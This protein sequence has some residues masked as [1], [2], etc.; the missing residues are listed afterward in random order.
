MTRELQ[1]FEPAGTIRIQP[2]KSIL[3]RAL[4]CAALADGT[5]TIRNFALSKDIEATMRVLEGL[6]HARFEY[7]N[8]LCTVR[9]GLRETPVDLLDCGES[10]T[11]LR[12][13]FPLALDGR[14]HVFTG[15][16][17]LME[18]P[19]GPYEDV[20][21]AQHI[22]LE[23]AGNGIQVCGQLHSAAVY[24]PGNVSSQFI[25]GLLLGFSQVSG[26][27]QII[28]TTPLESAPYVDLTRDMM[29]AFGAA[30]QA[31][32][33]TFLVRGPQL[34]TP[35]SLAAE[36]DYSHA[37]FFAAAAALAGEVTLEGLRR[38]SNQGDRAILEIVQDAGADVE[39]SGQGVTVSKGTL[40]PFEVDV[41]QI[42][43]LVP[44]LAVLACGAQG[45]ST[46][47][48]A[49]RLRFKESDRLAAMHEELSKMGA[50]VEERPDALVIDGS[51]R[52]RGG[53]VE[54]HNDHRIAMALA[55]A[56]LL[57]DAPVRIDG[58][59]SV[60]KSAPLFFEEWTSIG[61]K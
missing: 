28:V 59:D 29:A 38:D 16:G 5:S 46:L 21:R 50:I 31:E 2:S 12:L 14:P 34:M 55:V 43:D 26:V 52:L 7:G 18:R 37:A 53:D 49:A 4:I 1:P 56:S 45:R 44:I 23:R 42:P 9:G 33:D 48:N 24:M 47:N 54:A 32:G 51:G 20:C 8:G 35:C 6:G 13:T 60:S 19:F 27:S 36:G 41:S 22:A 3:H 61:G 15:A 39:W 25:S 30:V 57:A 40:R 58:A 10:G 17:R 11:T